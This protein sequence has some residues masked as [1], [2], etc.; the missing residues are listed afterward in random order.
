MKIIFLDID[1][2]ICTYRSHFANA[3]SGLMLDW[4]ATSCDLLRVL[5]R[6]T[7]ARIVVSSTWRLGHHHD[8]LFRQ[9]RKYNLFD[10]LFASPREDSLGVHWRTA[11][12]PGQVR[13]VEVDEW[14]TRH[15]A[16]SNYV[17]LDDSTDFLPHQ[18]ER[19]VNTEHVEGFGAR[20][21]IKACGILGD[22]EMGDRCL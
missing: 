4:D 1:G 5:C 10:H 14:L 15:S 18:M 22:R 20:D 13:G 19:F 9:L 12:I 8:D 16:V 21:F 7:D 2:V 6:R 17:I 3:G 11:S